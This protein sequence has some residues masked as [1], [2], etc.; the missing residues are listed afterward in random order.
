MYFTGNSAYG[1]TLVRK[2]NQ[3]NVTYHSSSDV[4]V[5][6][7]VNKKTFHHLQDI[8]NDLVELEADK[9]SVVIDMP[10]HIGFFVLDY[11]KLL[12]LRFYY[13]FLTEFLEPDSFCLVEGDT[14][15]MYMALATT[16]IFLAVKPEKRDQFISEYSKWFAVR[17]CGD[18]KASFFTAMF[19]DEPWDPC[20]QCT[21]VKTFDQR[22]VGKFHEEW[23]G[24]EM[25][26]LCSKCYYCVGDQRKLSSKGVSKQAQKDLD[27][28]EYKDVLFNQTIS[29]P[30]NRGFRV[31][32]GH[33]LTYSQQ[34]K[35]LNYMY[36]KRVVCDDHVTTLPTK[37]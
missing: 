36:G 17:F 30:T 25:V 5:A 16:T 7:L 19:A 15:S 3:R 32:R 21:R 22:T 27:E 18:H 10:V 20:E 13:A 35:G 37:L 28:S 8:G 9:N 11:S 29:K 33:M 1:H 6:S 26:A 4:G 31:Q 2:E 23:R 12:L 34:R 14:D 24:D